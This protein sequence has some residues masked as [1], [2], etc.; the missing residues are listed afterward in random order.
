M[1]ALGYP[2]EL[3]LTGGQ[4]HEA[5][6]APK[7]ING[8]CDYLI[9]DRGYDSNEIRA[10]CEE[11]NIVPVIPGRKIRKEKIEF[12]GHIYKE[13]NFIER[14]FA[15]IKHFRRIGTRYDKTAKMF[16]GGLTM[17]SILLWLKV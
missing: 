14:F 16:L 15:R 9:G 7:L 5:K 3:L 10:I 17:V 11:Q 12:D 1:D 8:E 13:R 2:L 6:I 4:D